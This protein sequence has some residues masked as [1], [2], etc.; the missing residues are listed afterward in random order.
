MVAATLEHLWGRFDQQGL[1]ALV[2]GIEESVL[3]PE[4][5]VLGAVDESVLDPEGRVLG[6]L[7]G[8]VLDPEGRVL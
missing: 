2:G 4:G 5:R 3:D 1:E 7:D 6:S 8:S